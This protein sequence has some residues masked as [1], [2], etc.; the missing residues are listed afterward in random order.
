V[1]WS[2][3]GA[4]L[5]LAVA[6]TG[7][8]QAGIAASDF[9][10]DLEQPIPALAAA[11]PLVEPTG[12]PRLAR[13][14]VIVVIDGLRVDV[15]RRLPYL[16]EL[17]RG[18][19]DAV[20][21]SG[22]PTWSRPNYV[23]ILTGVPPA[24]SGV[25]TNHFH[26]VVTLDSLM[27][28][29][30]DQPVP[31]RAGFG[32]D[33][34]P[35]P[36]LFL[37]PRSDG[38]IVPPLLEPDPEMTDSELTDEEA[39]IVLRRAIKLDVR[40][41]FD[42]THYE[43]WPGGFREAASTV[44]A[45][46]DGLAVLLVGAVDAAGHAYGGDSPEYA[47]AAFEVD[48]AL[49]DVL[50]G[51]DLAQDALI[52]VA[53]HGHSDNGGHGGLE[54]EVVEVPFILVG[55]G[56]VP[57]AALTDA[58]LSDVAPTAAALLGLPAPGH[59][60]GR[61]HLEALALAAADAA[62]IAVHDTARIERNKAL[63]DRVI[64]RAR[65]D[66]LDRRAL[67]GTLVAFACAIAVLLAWWLRK[68]GA[69]RLDIR[70]LIVGAP[71]FF[72]IYYTLIGTLGHRF[73]P[74]LLPDR[75]DIGWELLKY[76]A[77]GTVVHILTG[78]IALRRRTVLAERL[79]AAN[80]I[81]WLGLVLAM[82]PAGLVWAYY[83]APYVE[84]PGPRRLVLIPAINIAI[85]CYAVALTLSLLLEITVFFARAVDPRV[86]VER[87]ERAISLARIAVEERDKQV[88]RSP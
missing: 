58:Q 23:N 73:S 31:M 83:P 15:S 78:W 61:T 50:A 77:V 13:R 49:R 68:R 25:R 74:S 40:S 5:L 71:S 42:D 48:A 67:R 3:T 66:Q 52:V 54:P 12:A 43:P 56:I 64:Y 32:S 62:R 46:G 8:I 57:G 44:I 1:I 4:A 59:G 69:M 85:A 80:G 34:S 41:D 26:G 30:R 22:Y 29:V 39:A 9:M 76:G 79:S 27:D 84:V 88:S 86:R 82:V 75:G 7:A 19:I 47:A 2:V 16:N 37:R 53:D 10:G 70:V 60:I 21:A 45:T 14:V 51:L 17:R 18:G 63:V 38:P 20:A 24:L 33:Y 81:A 55:A 36:S 11:P 72:I 28:R 6:A 87:L 65:V 35:V